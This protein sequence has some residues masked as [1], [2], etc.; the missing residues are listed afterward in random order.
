[1]SISRNL[2]LT[3]LIALQLFSV[4]VVAQESDEDI[5]AVPKTFAVQ[6]RKYKLGSQYSAHLGY[7]PMDSFTKGVV[8]GASYTKYFTDFTGWEVI[9]A[10]WVMD[11][12]TGLKK[13][14]ESEFAADP[15]KLPDFPEWY[16]T[17]NIVYTPIYNKNLLFNKSVIW[18]DISFVG[19]AGAGSFQKDGIKPLVNGGAVLR[20]FLNQKESIKVDIREN[21]PFLSTGVEP[22]LFVGVG[23]TY[24]FESEVAPKNDE[25]DFEKEFTK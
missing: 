24:Q 15:G 4:N 12:D 22:F 16:I 18:G 3:L 23:Y 14:L 17:T 1:M 6:N 8:L 5:F 10:N 19:G 20:F 2:F 7:M 9:N 13:Q 21:L 25:D 11:I